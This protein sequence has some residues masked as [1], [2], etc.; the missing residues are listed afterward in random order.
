MAGA[1][2]RT[3]LLTPDTPTLVAKPAGYISSTV[4]AHKSATPSPSSGLI[5]FQL[6]RI[7][8]QI[9]ARANWRGLTKMD[10]TTCSAAYAPRAPALSARWS[11]PMVGTSATR[12]VLRNVPPLA[13]QIEVI[14][15]LHRPAP[16]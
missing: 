7:G 8:V 14:D 13:Q 2:R 9:L 12:P 10:A 3:A 4:G 5:G 15:G 6:A 1:R 11:A 16:S